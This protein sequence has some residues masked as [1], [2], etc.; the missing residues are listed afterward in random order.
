VAALPE[1]GDS[2]GLARPP[3]VLRRG[4]S[5]QDDDTRVWG[6]APHAASRLDAVEHGHVEV[7]EDNVGVELGGKLDRL[8][9]VPR[10][11]GDLDALVEL[12]GERQRFHEERVIVG[13][14]D[15]ELRLRLQVR[16]RLHGLTVRTG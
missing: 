7:H 15:A 4:R 8:L 12:E 14:H 1:E 5:G 3:L 9:A 13:D 6:D 2:A 11:A 16:L 10:A